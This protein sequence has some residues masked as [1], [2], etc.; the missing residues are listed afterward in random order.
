MASSLQTQNRLFDG[1]S[2]PGSARHALALEGE[3]PVVRGKTCGLRNQCSGLACL[4]LVRI[5]FG[6]GTL[7]NAVSCEDD[8]KLCARLAKCG[9][10]SGLELF[11]E[12][13]DKQ[14]MVMP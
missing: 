3:G 5:A 14:G 7:R 13:P 8:R 4:C 10:P 1:G 12:R 9:F 2:E 6:D 11:N